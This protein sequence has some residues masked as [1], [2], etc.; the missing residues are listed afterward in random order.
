MEETGFVKYDTV[1]SILEDAGFYG[2]TVHVEEHGRKH[3]TTF[4]SVKWNKTVIKVT[5]L[6]LEPNKL[7]S[8]KIVINIDFNGR[9]VEG[10]GDFK[11]A[12]G[13]LGKSHERQKKQE[14]QN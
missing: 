9:N 2:F 11:K 7:G 3:T 14:G 5:T 4:L 13:D 6:K 12:I 1:K 8:P 10:I